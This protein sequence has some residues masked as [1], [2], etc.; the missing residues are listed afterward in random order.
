MKKSNI[1]KKF[2]IKKNEERNIQKFIDNLV[3]FNAHTN[4]V[5]KSTLTNPWN[6]HIL[7]SLQIL[8]HIKNKNFSIID[9]GTG[10]GL[11]GVV[12]S[13]MGCKNI[14]LVDSKR[15]KIN[16]LSLLKTK[17]FL[18]YSTILGRVENIKNLKYDIVTSRALANLETLFTY[19]QNFLKKKTVIIFLKG[20]TVN[21]EIKNAEV[22]WSFEYTKIQSLSDPRGSVLLIKNLKKKND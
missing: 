2:S 9:M 19:S 14:T 22:G 13:I 6:N 18:K 11:P 3:S 4:L 12:L 5:G 16:F 15:K 8:P 1:I 20:K 10:A 7:D 17:M 21:D